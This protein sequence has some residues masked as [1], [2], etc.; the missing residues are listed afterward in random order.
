M[1]VAF[2]AN[3]KTMCIK[4]PNLLIANRL[5]FGILKLFL[6]FKIPFV[7]RIK[8]KHIKPLIKKAKQYKNF[9]IVNDKTRQGETIIVS[10]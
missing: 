3:G 9:E 2:P 6:A 5:S 10:L 4:I 8:Y 1:K 7:F